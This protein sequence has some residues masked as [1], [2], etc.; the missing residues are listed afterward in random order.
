MSWRRGEPGG[1]PS[2]GPAWSREPPAPARR[3]PRW[4]AVRR[5]AAPRHPPGSGCSASPAPAAASPW[6]GP[7]H[8]D[9]PAPGRPAPDRSG[10]SPPSQPRRRPA[11]AGPGGT[12][13]SDAIATTAGCPRDVRTNRAAASSPPSVKT[14]A[15][16]PDPAT[17]HPPLTVPPGCRIPGAGGTWHRRIRVGH[18]VVAGAPASVVNRVA[19]G[20]RQPRVR[21]RGEAADLLVGAPGGGPRGSGGLRVSG[22][23]VGLTVRR[24]VLIHQHLDEEVGVAA[25]LAADVRLGEP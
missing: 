20:A 14:T 2:S 13:R 11:G 4:A 15:E 9:S 3:R 1:G 5:S 21:G 22:Q 7:P 18:E 23:A 8:L 24:G 19:A 16:V 12:G 6:C 10:R 25:G 17:E